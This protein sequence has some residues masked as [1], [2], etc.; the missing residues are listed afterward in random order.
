HVPDLVIHIVIIPGVTIPSLVT[1]WIRVQPRRIPIYKLRLYVGIGFITSTFPMGNTT[2]IHTFLNS[3]S[4]TCQ[5]RG[6]KETHTVAH[7][8]FRLQT[9]N[10]E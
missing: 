5:W 7:F 1:V 6:E 3:F 9:N 4:Q 10:R 2:S 8:C